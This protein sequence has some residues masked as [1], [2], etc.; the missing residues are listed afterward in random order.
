M[1]AVRNL[2]GMT[3][4]TLQDGLLCLGVSFVSVAWFEVYKTIRGN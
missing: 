4:I 3:R 1:P 2:F